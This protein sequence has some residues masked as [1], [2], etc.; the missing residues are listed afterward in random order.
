MNDWW[1]MN[2][3]TIE[4]L[5]PCRETKTAP[6]C[7]GPLCMHTRPT[8]LNP[9]KPHL[10]GAAYTCKP[11][12]SYSVW[13]EPCLPSNYSSSQNSTGLQGLSQANIVKMIHPGNK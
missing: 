9:Y 10:C 3:A 13:V 11:S 2:V 8:S 1:V 7:P 12:W 6:V 5:S 4:N